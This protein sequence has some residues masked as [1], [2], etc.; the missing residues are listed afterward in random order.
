MVGAIDLSGQRFG[1]LLVV[2]RAAEKTPS[3]N[4][5][6]HCACDCGKQTIIPSGGLRRGHYQSCGCMQ[7][8]GTIT[9]GETLGGKR[10][11]EYITWNSIKDRCENPRD[12]DYKYYGARGI[13]MCAYWRHSFNNFLADMGRRPRPELSI[14]R[15]DSDGDYEPG[16][17]RWATITEQNQNRRNVIARRGAITC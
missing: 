1:K 13:K 5:R 17:C 15:I 2:E 3:G 12:A 7:K 4:L 9:H 8:K 16:N 11:V 10:S 6:W 14:D